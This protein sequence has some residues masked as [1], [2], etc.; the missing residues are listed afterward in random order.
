MTLKILFQA[1]ETKHMKYF[2]SF[3]CVYT[4]LFLI[5]MKN[6]FWLILKGEEQQAWVDRE[7]NAAYL[8]H[9]LVYVIVVITL[10]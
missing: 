4:D 1:N 7:K 6:H 9:L 5:H 10:F 8:D 2:I 3:V